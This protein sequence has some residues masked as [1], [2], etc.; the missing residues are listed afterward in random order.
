MIGQFSTASGTVIGRD[1]LT[2]G[3][4]NQDAFLVSSSS[5]HTLIMCGDGCSSSPFSE[6]GARAGLPLLSRAIETQLARFSRRPYPVSLEKPFPFWLRVSEDFL[7]QIRVL[8]NAMGES[9]SEVVFDYFLF[10][11]VGALI[12]PWGTTIFSSG[13]GLYALNGEVVKIGPFP[14]NEPPYLAYALTD[15]SP[16]S[17]RER[18]RLV[19]NATVPTDTVNQVLVATDGAFFL[20]EKEGSNLPGRDEVVGPLS[21]FWTDDAFFDNPDEIRRRLSAIASDY[22]RPD[23]EARQMTKQI[24]LLPDDTTLAVARRTKE[25]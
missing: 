6:V 19:I 21:Q 15:S 3:R 18:P 12:T 10:A 7:S 22:R 9:L 8:A 25:A 2:A 11:F 24:G 1:H 17:V 16:G 13:D 23:W 20:V 4:N 14:G 5:I